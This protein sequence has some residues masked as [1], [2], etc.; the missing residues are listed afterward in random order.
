M[1]DDV[2]ARR[3][4]EE[5]GELVRSVR[6]MAMAARPHMGSAELVVIVAGRS[7]GMVL[8]GEAVAAVAAAP[9]APAGRST[10]LTGIRTMAGRRSVKWL[11]AALL[12]VGLVAS[13]W[14]L[15]RVVGDGET[16]TLPVIAQEDPGRVEAR[17]RIVPPATPERAAIPLQLLGGDR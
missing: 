4:G 7:G 14:G 11:A 3:V 13:G 5:E 15:R 9:H 16:R 1:G 10:A 12:A 2:S 8:D 6:Q 17:A